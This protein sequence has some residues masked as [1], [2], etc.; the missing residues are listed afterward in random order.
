QEHLD[1]L[2]Q[3]VEVWNKWREEHPDIQPDLNSVE[4]SRTDLS[5]ANFAGAYLVEADLSKTTLVEAN[6]SGAILFSVDLSEAT[7]V[8]ADLGGKI[9][10]RTTIGYTLLGDVDLSTARGLDTINHTMPSTI[11][12]DTIIR[13]KGKIST[14]FLEN[15]GVPNS[16]IE[17]M[18]SLFGSLEP[19]QYY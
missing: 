14:I 1:I 19:I 2:K 6:L 13:S 8:G 16:I 18:P 7:L 3:G 12:I 4:L 10:R 9:I 15:A 17:A 11:G 5:R